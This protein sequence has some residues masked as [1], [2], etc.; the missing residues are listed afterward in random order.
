MSH[1]DSSGVLEEEI[2]AVKWTSD[3]TGC[4]GSWSI[5]WK[6]LLCPCFL[7]AENLEEINH[8][9]DK[10]S[11]FLLPVYFLHW[12][13]GKNCVELPFTIQNFL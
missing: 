7:Y 13:F 10:K 1:R 6:G 12:L 2:A 4:F 8:D 5:L 11:N 9:H 3:L